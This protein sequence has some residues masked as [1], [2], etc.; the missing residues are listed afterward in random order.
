MDAL[1][2]FK[3]AANDNLELRHSLRSI[4]K[5]ASY[6]RKV[7]IFGDKPSF[8]SDDTRVIE[9][10][11]EEYLA[12]VL[13]IQAP[14]RNFFLLILLSSL[15]PDLDFEYLRFSDD[16]FLLKDF[17]IEEARKDRYFEDL[18]PPTTQPR[19]T[20]MWRDCLWRT[21]DL[22]V[23]LGYTAFNFEI[24]APM[25]MTRK[26]VLDA[27]CEFRDFVTEDRWFGMMGATAILNH[28]HKHEQTKLVSIKEENS[29][30][31]FWAKPPMTYEAVLEQA[32]GKTYFN[33][34]DHAF[35]DHIARFLRKRYPNRSRFESC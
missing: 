15:I 14:V 12:R 26:R 5:H 13:G 34:D 23:R 27:Y 17:P 22:L 7:W 11:P 18:T 19:G 2:L 24:H 35:N 4:E 29:R 16:F 30:A 25:F 8:I 31:G 33:F 9:H 3:Q 6:I 28:A 32:Q 20:G 21:R 10:I 1:Y